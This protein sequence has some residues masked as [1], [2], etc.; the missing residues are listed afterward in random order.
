MAKRLIRSTKERCPFCYQLLERACTKCGK[1]HCTSRKGHGC[2]PLVRCD[3]APRK[4][5]WAKEI[6][7]TT[8]QGFKILQR[9]GMAEGP[10]HLDTGPMLRGTVRP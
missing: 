5:R 2:V 6:Y 3:N 1:F 10:A 4:K 9:T 7:E 8:P